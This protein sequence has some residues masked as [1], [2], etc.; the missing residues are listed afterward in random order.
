MK[1]KILIIFAVI[2][3]ILAGFFIFK[4]F[5]KKSDSRQIPAASGEYVIFQ[6]TKTI[7]GEEIGLPLPKDR[8]VRNPRHAQTQ[9]V[10]YIFTLIGITKDSVTIRNELIEDK[11]IKNKDCLLM[12]VWGVTDVFYKYCFSL[13]NVN[14]ITNITYESKTERWRGISG[15]FNTESTV[16][17]EVKQYEW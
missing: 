13:S 15:T 9:D 3:I 17:S 7:L 4:N 2:I 1:R 16:S 5:N 11:I 8:F 10:G 12:S 14:S 6:N